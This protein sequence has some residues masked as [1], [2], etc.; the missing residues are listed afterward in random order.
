MKPI[1][2]KMATTAAIVLCSIGLAAC[3]GGSSG[4]GTGGGARS[5]TGIPLSG[6]DTGGSTPQLPQQ[7]ETKITSF[8]GGYVDGQSGLSSIGVDAAINEGAFTLAWGIQSSSAVRMDLYV[9]KDDQLS[10]ETD[11]YFYG[12][13]CYAVNGSTTEF[14]CGVAQCKFES[15][16]RIRCGDNPHINTGVNLTDFLEA[17]P[18][19]DYLIMNLCDT[20]GNCDQ[21]SIGI[22]FY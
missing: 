10:K 3:G 22:R 5:G 18:E 4:S 17:L 1:V 15:N 2:K 12:D 11:E 16:N 14:D 19:S 20:G 6:G 13:N 7:V 9:S 8:T 21:A